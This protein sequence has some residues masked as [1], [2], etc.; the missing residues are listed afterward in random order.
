MSNRD[1]VPTAP[2]LQHL[3]Q[4]AALAYLSLRLNNLAELPPL[5]Q[6]GRHLVKVC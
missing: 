3:T 1:R 4:P 2:R 6:V 5:H